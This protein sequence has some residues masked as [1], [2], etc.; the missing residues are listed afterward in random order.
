MT[1][2]DLSLKRPVLATVFNLLVVLAGVAA[3]PRLPVREYPDVDNPVVAVTTVY[4]GAS[5]ETVESTI[6]EPLEQTLNGVDDIRS[7]QSISSLGRSSI[8]VEF[9]AGRD[10]DLAV[11]DVTNAIQR[12]LGDLPDDA[13]RPI[14]AKTGAN[15]RPIIWLYITSKAYSD[16]DLTDIADRMVKTPIQL[17]PGVASVIIGGERRYAMRV[18]LDPV[19]MAERHVDPSDL[20][21]AIQANNLQIAA[22]EIEGTTRKFTVLADA[23]IDDPKLFERIV[24]REDDGAPVRIGDVGWVELGSESYETITR[25]SREPIVGI[26]IIRQSRANELAVSKAVREAM[27]AIQSTLPPGVE[28][29]TAVDNTIFVEASLKE[30]WKTLGMAFGLVVLVNL[31]FLRST[32]TTVITSIAIPISLIGTFAALAVL[33]FSVNLLTL[34]ALVLAIGLLVDDAI[35]VLENIYRRQETGEPP[36]VAARRG[37]RE[38]GFAVIA[39]TVSLIAVLI[40][41]SL[42]TGSTGRLFRE[43][44]LTM[45]VAVAI[46]TLTALTIVPVMC[47][48]FLKL[49]PSHG[50]VY[51]MIERFL[52]GIGAAYDAALSWSLRHRVVLGV[53]V[54]AMLAASLWLYFRI[55]STFV[56][57]E[58]RG[59]V[60]TILRAP[61][62]STLSY[63]NETLKKIEEKLASIPEI[64]GFFAEIGLPLGG[65]PSTAS[66][67]AIARMVHWDDRTVSQQEIV[68][69]LFPY[70]LSFPGA[71]VFTIN[72]PSLGQQSLSDVELV[73]QNSSATLDDLARASDAILG[74][75]RQIPGLINADTNLR[76]DNPQLALAFDRE[77]IHD[78]GLTIE[79]VAAAL[80]TLLAEVKTSEFVFRNK[81]YDVITA[82]AARNREVPDQLREI[83]LRTPSGEMVPLDGLV[84]PIPTIAA[85]QLNHYDLQ[86]SATLTANLAP[87]ATLGK[88]LDQVKQIADE[89]LGAGFSTAWGGQSR[90]YLEASAEVYLTF[91]IGIVFIYLVLAAQFESFFHP[92]TILFSVPLAALGALATLKLSGN[93]INLYSQIGMILLLGLVTKNSI[94]LVDYANQGRARG[95]ALV[96]AV[97]LA[98]KTRFRPILMT[99][100]TSILGALP[101]LLA[102]GAGAESRHPIGAVV[103]GGLLFSTA[104]TLL[105][106]PVVYLGV[107]WIAEGLGFST[108]PPLIELGDIDDVDDAAEPGA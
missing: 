95:L 36:H 37:S 103:V 15:T 79:S 1:L 3:Y 21:R 88:A 90:E 2:S 50:A 100:V 46:S 80:Q 27:P 107:V 92:I 13:E 84:R 68:G 105:V 24:I 41:L 82:L 104:F 52:D 19:K 9:N 55:P 73:I 75:M 106:I 74:R 63:T 60:L 102:A 49:S 14:V 64:K 16:V 89:E 97:V 6:T 108:I 86:R 72:P 17:L 25:F 4:P 34:L 77:R 59:Y 61:Q 32:A 101:L 76:L 48:K 26:G 47:D 35:V 51:R 43:F 40:P 54:A 56:P 11:T 65:P 71:L 94:L 42:L 99:S 66:G 22:G 38:V 33:G 39:T 96:E 62:G 30:V 58:D 53:G 83:Q 23:Q 7:I 67:L 87:G 20:R 70:F 28:L 93:T 31:F 44:A 18:W 98:G 69:G 29:K 57:V 12:A 91:L 78:L 81:Q 10:I 8:S 5:P 45:A 85:T